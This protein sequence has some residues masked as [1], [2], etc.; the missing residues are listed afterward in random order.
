M[1]RGTRRV[2][3]LAGPVVVL[4]CIITAAALLAGRSGNSPNT[5]VNNFT[6]AMFSDHSSSAC[7]WV[8]PSQQPECRTAFTHAA[9]LGVHFPRI[10]VHLSVA[11]T[12]LQGSEALV[13]LVGRLCTSIHRARS[14]RTC[15]ANSNASMGLPSGNKNF[16]TAFSNVVHRTSGSDAYLFIFPCRKQHGHWYI[17]FGSRTLNAQA[18]RISQSSLT[19]ALTLA[20]TYYARTQDFTPPAGTLASILSTYGSGIT[21]HSGSG[22]GVSESPNTVVVSNTSAGGLTSTSPNAVLLTAYSKSGK[23]WFILDIE[24]PIAGGELGVGGG[25]LSAHGAGVYYGYNRPAKAGQCKPSDAPTAY[26]SG[27]GSFNDVWYT[28]FQQP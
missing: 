2:A 27:A 13:V 21:W 20:K 22:G 3:L 5:A 25:K 24:E 17:D 12:Q 18:N 10:A 9:G 15:A 1:T 23:C 6:T 26:Y 7:S 16:Q 14:R 11:H 19:N 8:L 28:K 4:A